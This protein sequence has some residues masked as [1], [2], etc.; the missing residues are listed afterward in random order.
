MKNKKEIIK[1]IIIGVI[2]SILT[3]IILT[4]PIPTKIKA[5][6]TQPS[7]MIFKTPLQGF[8]FF[9]TDIIGQQYVGVNTGRVYATSS[10]TNEI[11]RNYF[12]YQKTGKR[13]IGFLYPRLYCDSRYMNE[14]CGNSYLSPINLGKYAYDVYCPISR[15][16]MCQYGFGFESIE[17]ELIETVKVE[18]L[19]GSRKLMQ[20]EYKDQ[21]KR[22]EWGLFYSDSNYIAISRVS[23]SS[24]IYSTNISGNNINST[25][26]WMIPPGVKSD[27]INGAVVFGS[28]VNNQYNYVPIITQTPDEN[29]PP[30]QVATKEYVDKISQAGTYE[31]RREKNDIIV[32]INGKICAEEFGAYLY[33]KRGRLGYIKF[34]TING[35]VSGFHIGL[36]NNDNS[37]DGWYINQGCGG[38]DWSCYDFNKIKQNSFYI[39]YWDWDYVDPNTPVV[40]TGATGGKGYGSGARLGL[41]WAIYPDTENS[42]RLTGRQFLGNNYGCNRNWW[43]SVRIP[44]KE[45]YK[46]V[47]PDSVVYIYN[48]PSNLSKSTQKLQNA[49]DVFKYI[50]NKL[51][52]YTRIHKDQ[53]K[54][55]IPLDMGAFIELCGD[56]DGCQVY[57]YTASTD[58]DDAALS[59]F[60]KYN[61]ETG[62]F[63]AGSEAKTESR[64]KD[65]DGT[66]EWILA[67]WNCYIITDGEYAGG[68]NAGDNAIGISSYNAC[69]PTAVHFIFKD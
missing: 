60:V 7:Y 53:N 11:G 54:N 29:S 55:S 24:A 50:N 40:I 2:I 12:L 69:S 68:R 66:H 57:V 21:E 19:Y 46:N 56:I 20:L 48:L 9:K 4:S 43:M 13:Y 59:N 39:L 25:V 18:P 23:T 58:L 52:S 32:T 49:V 3:I 28:F 14:E 17:Y 15:I 45:E 65:G 36:D 38:G 35:R 33:E 44:L 26:I 1:G 42:F 64:G 16:Q 8:K 27:L 61:P 63:V 62:K 41:P 30:N 31:V 6:T 67:A 47:S 5:Q 37:A 22:T 10:N 51:V 34:T